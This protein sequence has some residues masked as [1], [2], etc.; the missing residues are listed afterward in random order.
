MESIWR[1][2]VCV[3]APLDVWVEDEYGFKYAIIERDVISYKTRLGLCLKYLVLLMKRNWFTGSSSWQ[4]VALQQVSMHFLISHSQTADDISWCAP[5][6]ALLDAYHFSSTVKDGGSLG[7][8][9]TSLTRHQEPNKGN[10][11]LLI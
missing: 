10:A 8:S 2:G 6:C 1:E 11:F 7:P 5:S 3:L 4:T 9:T